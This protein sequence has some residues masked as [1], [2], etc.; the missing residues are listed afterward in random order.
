[1]PAAGRHGGA[2][3][4]WG[5]IRAANPQ[6]HRL[7]VFLR[8][9]VDESG[10]T[11]AA[12]ATA[13][14]VSRSQISVYLGG[15]IPTQRFVTAVVDATVPTPLRERRHEEADRLLRD[16][17]HPPPAPPAAG[18]APTGF[19]ELTQLQ[20][21]QIETY[22]RLTRALEQQADLR[23]TA[24]NSAKL[25]MVL[26][27]MVHELQNRITRLTAERDRL[28]HNE[29][30]TVLEAAQRKLGRAAAQAQKARQELQRAEERKRQAEELA[31]RLQQKI[32]ELTDDLDRLRGNEPYPH[33]HLPGLAAAVPPHAP[34]P[35][36]EDPEGDDFDTALAR[37]S[38]INDTDADAVDRIT[39][40]LAGI[41]P[42][43][44]PNVL[45]NPSTSVNAPNN[46]RT[47]QEIASRITQ[48]E[49]LEDPGDAATA[50]DL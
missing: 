31:D 50:R 41:V 13:I 48:A 33:D 19:V 40:Q 24:D 3:R 44:G 7:A 30:D 27:S 39:T 6:A 4:S 38:A 17:L 47:E 1:M 23:Q 37:A 25:V 28:T 20:A 46:I 9:R 35:I 36:S 26:L 14:D 49:R 34:G 8:A 29:Q 11:L 5:P 18:P 15:K 16:A 32:E 43:S 22:D 42:D 21:R 12:L 2:G 10:K 45:D